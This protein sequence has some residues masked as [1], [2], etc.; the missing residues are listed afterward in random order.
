MS[1]YTRRSVLKVGGSVLGGI[2]LGST[3]T[4]AES[5][6]RY[7]VDVRRVDTADAREA[8]LEIVHDLSAIDMLVVR[9]IE[10]DVESLNADYAPDTRYALNQPLDNRTPITV[11]ESDTTNEPLYSFQW[12]KQAQNI[13]DAHDV[14]RG[15]ETRVTV[16][17]TGVA[18]GHPD[19]QHAVNEDLSRNFTDDDYGAG[20]PY[21]G[22][23]G[24]HVT[25]II[26]A[27][28]R[29][30]E[31][32][33]GSSPATEV[34]DCRVF[35][36]GE[37]AA[38]ADIIAAIVYSANI[39]ADA[40]NMSI[41]AYPVSRE[42]LG[43]FYGRVLN[44]ATSYAN[45]QGTLL[46]AAA[47]NASADLQHDGRICGD[48][49]DD[50]EEECLPAISLPNEAANTMSISAT[51]PVGFM[52]DADG[53]SNTS[54]FVEP[55]ESPAFYT[56]Y[57][58]NA[59]DIGA[60]GGDVHLPSYQ[61]DPNADNIPWYLDLVLSTVS[62]PVFDDDGNYVKAE[63]SYGWA[64]GTSM[65]APQVTEAA[66]LVKS[67]NLRYTP[68]QVRATL[69]RTADTVDEYDKTYYGSGFLN[70]ADAVR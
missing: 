1:Q 23:H 44:R 6:D 5:A 56:N 64:A 36:P 2:A 67:Q 39:G 31:G 27:N 3:V 53:D 62:E 69:E 38:F 25:G 66:A 7:L 20:G 19:L 45:Q 18:A 41:G 16:I 63:H 49:D 46:V 13:P 70:P 35:S 15:E 68:N 9:G 12:G 22:Y 51:G 26:A 4:V 50:G 55:P 11:E 29:N 61:A 33:T 34:V 48:F 52:W 24:T 14:T 65:A 28:D 47:G 42:G 58:T 17:D 8:G 37:L 60:P 30:E 57:G 54:D 40:A 10:S 43:Q 32:V 59:I 21:G